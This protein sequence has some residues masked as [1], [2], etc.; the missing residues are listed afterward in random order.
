[1]KLNKNLILY[2][3]LTYGIVAFAFLIYAIK[4]K[5]E[6]KEWYQGY[7]QS[8]ICKHMSIVLQESM[9]DFYPEVEIEDVDLLARLMTAEMGYGAS[10]YE[11][12]L[13]GIVVWNR[14]KSDDFPDTLREVIY[15]P[16]QYQCVENGHIERDWDELAWEIA[17]AVL[18]TGT[19]DTGVPDDLVFQA[20]FKQG[21][22]VYEHIGRTYF[23]CK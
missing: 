10:D 16:G 17:E 9:E 21:S 14:M 4:P 3:I 18:E 11:Y 6:C 5:A 20:E 23:C 19:N 7:P 8:G 2:I 22:E 13:T 12:Y 15:Q 1:M